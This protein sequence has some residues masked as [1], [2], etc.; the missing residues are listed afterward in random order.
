VILG[1]SDVYPSRRVVLIAIFAYLALLALYRVAGANRWR[2]MQN[3]ASIAL[4]AFI[5]IEVLPIG[6]FENGFIDPCSD[7]GAITGVD[8][9]I[10]S[11][12]GQAAFRA[13]M[14]NEARVID[15]LALVVYGLAVYG[16]ASLRSFL[17]PWRR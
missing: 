7:R 5:A 10:P 17:I 8:V 16:L 15:L 13:A 3:A 2:G 9:P 14:A 12:C 6:L 1:F 11:A 4:M